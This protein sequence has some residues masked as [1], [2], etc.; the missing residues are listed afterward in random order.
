MPIL[1][2]KWKKDKYI[3]DLHDKYNSLI[4]AQSE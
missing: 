3:K 2:G 1:K 4:Y